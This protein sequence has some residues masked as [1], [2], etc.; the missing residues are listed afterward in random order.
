V[1][2]ILVAVL[3]GQVLVALDLLLSKLPLTKFWLLLV[4]LFPVKT[5]ANPVVPTFRTGSSSTN[6]TSQ[7]VV[8]ESITSYQYRTG[9]SLS[10]SGT[11]IES[12]DVNGYINSIPTAESTQSVNG[13]NFSYTSPSLEG[14]PRWKIVNQGQPFS[15]VETVIGSGIDTITKID[16]VINTTTT[17]TVETTFGQ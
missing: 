16:R 8:T 10:V 7:S 15:L 9:Y 17:T 1:V 4:I 11:N 3:S 12:A 2:F 6:S 5:L 14:V 13:I